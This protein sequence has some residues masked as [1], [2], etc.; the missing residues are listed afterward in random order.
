M[1]VKIHKIA[2]PTKKKNPNY[3]W[4]REV[5]SYSVVIKLQDE[6]NHLSINRINKHL[7]MFANKY[8]TKKN[9]NVLWVSV[10]IHL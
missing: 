7:T 5:T 6:E 9:K 1:D 2:S 10:G 3:H 8:W 4:E